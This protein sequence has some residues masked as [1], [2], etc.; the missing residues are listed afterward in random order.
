MTSKF[1]IY[2]HT[3][4]S[5]NKVF[6]VGK[7]TGNRLRVRRNNLNWLAALGDSDF[8]YE[9]LY[10]N[11]SEVQAYDMES[12]L[13]KTPKEDWEL[14]NYTYTVSK[15]RPLT[16]DEV[17]DH[18]Y[19]DSSSPSGIRW[20]RDNGSSNPKTKRC[21]GDIAGTVKKDSDGCWCGYSVRLFGRH[22]GT[23]RIVWVLNGNYLEQGKV[24]DHIDGNTWNNDI[25]NL[26]QATYAENTQNS[27]MGKNNTTGINGVFNYSVRG[28]YCWAAS[29]KKDGKPLLK[30]FSC[31]KY[32][33][34]QAK[35]LAI[36]FRQEYEKT[37]N[38][39]E[40]HG[41]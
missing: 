2:T 7:G 33:E 16:F 13:I 27:K 18:F 8:T 36:E 37:R 38:F 17:C 39:S 32:G 25:S 30:T 23:H 40:R 24:I 1:Y 35:Q 5:D 12:H 31:N 28:V 15:H 26:R 11:L 34:E 14:C 19:Y 29:Y 9:V 4:V 41:K 22:I 21:K 20:S 3:R 6:Y 10:E